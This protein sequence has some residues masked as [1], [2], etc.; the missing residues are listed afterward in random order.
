MEE[1]HMAV[2]YQQGF[3]SLE[4]ELEVAALTV[5]GTLPSWLHG[6]LVR[7]GPAK[8]EVGNKQ[9]N[10][11]FDGLAML[12][13]FSFADGV[14]SYANKFIESPS[15]CYA[16]Q[17]GKIGYSEFATDPC[18]SIFKRVTSM[19]VPQM[20][21][22]TS[23][24]VGKI[25]EQFVAWT[26]TPLPIEFDPHSLRTVG[27]VQFN[28]A[29]VAHTTTP[30]PQIDPLSGEQVN[31]SLKFGSKSAYQVYTFDKATSGR[32]LL[33]TLS[34]QE[35]AYM[36]SFGLSEHYV[37]LV[38]YPLVVNPLK[39]L[40]SG[41]PF[42]ENLRWQPERGTN[43]LIVRKSDGKLLGKYACDP[44]FCF[45]HV[46]AFERD[47]ELVVDLIAYRDAEVIRS[48]YLDVLRCASTDGPRQPP[49]ELRRYSITLTTGTIRQELLSDE[50]LELP[51][52]NYDRSHTRDYRYV[53]GTG[54]SKQQPH[55]FSNQ[56][57]KVNIL[58]RSAKT[59]YVPGMYPG[60]P[61]FVAAPNAQAE[62]DGVVLSVVLDAV[63]GGSYLLI[64]DAAR[65]TEIGRVPAPHRI[66]FGF[67]GQFFAV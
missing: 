61:V 50:W 1:Q 9:L 28:D 63:Q 67:H 4:Q 53:Y 18:R 57:V 39:M 33:S 64:L 35:P 3:D 56:L 55:D 30:H 20:G 16:R 44:F 24:S 2:G 40:L 22:N 58:E 19:F 29:V 7:N 59:W 46:N 32:K 6:T 66:P 26:E 54:L 15:Y 34:V 14:V 13:K 36:H 45:H 43:F 37:I 11:W 5:I 31:V 47:D 21:V 17:H 52:I 51:R 23:V 62:D 49:N 42:A 65:F 25:A 60:E 41:K 10:H 12:H 8:F 38:E 48:L 27:V